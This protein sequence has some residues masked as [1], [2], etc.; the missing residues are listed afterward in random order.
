MRQQSKSVICILISAVFFALMSIFVRMAGDLPTMQKC[1][2]RNLFASIFILAP[3]LRKRVKFQIQKGHLRYHFMRVVPGAVGYIC[4]F[5]SVDHMS[6]ADANVLT[7]L[8]PF[9]VILISI[10]VL[11]EKPKKADIGA[12]LLAFIG[13]LFV[14]RPTFDSKMVPG[15]IGVLG[16]F[17]A[18]VAYTYVRKLT[19]LGVHPTQIIF[20]FFCFTCLISLPFVLL[21]H[22]P[23]AVRQILF[24]AAA[25]LAATLAQFAIT[26]AYSISPGKRISIF[27]YS[28][29]LFSAFFA[30]LLLHETPPA[31]SWLGY[32][33]II[34]AAV[35]KWRYDNKID[36]LST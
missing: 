35:L 30:F 1:F 19:Q 15:L 12:V 31:H 28:Q 17:G 34:G 33:I 20:E 2:F 23:I 36:A 7:K 21:D 26:L 32:A 10:P 25:G 18:G 5:Y 14:V 8:S 24:L 11:K 22:H 6:I 4:N 16:G 27:E 3:A 9:F 29:I 13:L